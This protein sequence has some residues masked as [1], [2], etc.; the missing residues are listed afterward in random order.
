M[1]SPL[2]ARLPRGHGS[3][4]ALR[5]AIAGVA[6]PADRAILGGVTSDRL[7]HAFAAG[8]AAALARLAGDPAATS[9]CVTEEGG[10]HPRAIRTTLSPEGRLRGAKAWST[11][12][13]D[14]DVLLV[15]ASVGERDGRNELRVARVAADAPG[16]MRTPMPA[17]P[18]APEIGHWRVTFADAPVLDVLPGDGWERY[19]RP[20]RT[21][22]DAHVCL[23]TAAYLVG[24]ARAYGWPRDSAERLVAD[25]VL[26]R[27]IAGLAPDEPAVHVALAGA[28]AGLR[29]RVVATDGLWA[30]VDPEEAARWRRDVA[31]LQVADRA[32]A[33]RA[34]VAWG[35]LA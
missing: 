29:E 17:T 7:G 22:E 35:R 6:E 5:E 1:L 33:K 25:V 20:F 34:E 19:V 12:A 23:A 26:L 30:S 21:V 11:L 28:I 13:G 24:V 9:L 3:L 15:A 16:V 27:A 31:L 2:F 8:Y 32:R 14:A 18:F 4:A 10:A